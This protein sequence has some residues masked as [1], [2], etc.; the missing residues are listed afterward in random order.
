MKF[1]KALSVF[2]GTI[3]GVGIFGLPYVASKAGFFVILFYFLAMS[4]I[5]IVIHLL[6]SKV[7]LGTETLYR[8]PGFVGEYMISDAYY[9]VRITKSSILER[10]AQSAKP[11]LSFPEVDF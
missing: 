5:A 11:F 6:F 4:I 3:I 7:A 8:L 9:F 1:I 10:F 2:V